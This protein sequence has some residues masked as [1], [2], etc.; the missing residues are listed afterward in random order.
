[1]RLVFITERPLN[2]DEANALTNI[3]KA[4]IP[5]LDP[6]ISR[7]VQ[8]NYIKR[9]H[10]V[11]HPD[12]DVL[13]DIPTIGWVRAAQDY[14]AVPADLTHKARWAKAQGHHVDIAEHPNAEAGVRGIGSDASVRSHL[15][16]AVQHL[17]LA[18]PVPE[19]VSFADHSIAIV[20]QLQEMV[21]QHRT[22]IESNLRRHHRYWSDVLQ[23]LPD[24]MIDWA[25]W[26]LDHPGALKR[27]TI[28]L[29]KEERK[30]VDAAATREAIYAHVARTIER[31]RSGDAIDPFK[32][33]ANEVLET[34]PVVL[35]VA[36]TGSRKST[37]MRDAAV[38][39]VA[40]HPE[41]SVVILMPRHKLG[42]EQIELLQQK[43]SG[44]DAA[45]W[46]GRHAWDPEIRG[47]KMCW[48]EEEAKELEMALLNVEHHLC[49][50]GRGEKA[51]KC[52]FFD[53]C[54][55]QRQKQ[56][57][58][59]IW[60][61]AH[62]CMTHEMPKV[63]GKVGWVIIDES[64]LDA[65]MFGID[66]ND[67][68]TLVLDAL[69]SP[70]PETLNERD[71]VELTDGRKALYRAL[72]KLRVPIEHY[73]GIPVSR[74]SLSA[75]INERRGNAIRIAKYD[76]KHLRGLEWRGKVEPDIRPD[77]TKKE[78]LEELA[79]AAGNG[80]VKKCAT[81]WQ[82]IEEVEQS[83]DKLH[84]RIQVHRGEGR[85]IRMVGLHELAKGWNV[86]TLICDA[87][88]NAK[89]LRAIWPQLEED[90]MQDWQQ[91]PRPK[92]VRVF[93]CVN[94]SISKWAIAI[95][96]NEK[97]LAR[98]I[99]SARRVY[100]AVLMKALEYGGA[101]VGV[102]IYKATETWIRENCCVPEWLK[103]YHHGDVTGT[104]A[105]ANVRALFVIGRPLASPEDVTRQA[106]ALFGTYIRQR[107]YR[108]RRKQGRI[109]IVPDAAGNN[110]ILVD[111]WEHPNPRAERVRRQVTEA[112]LIQAVG[113]ARAGLR[114]A[115]EPLDIHLWTDVPLPELGP[116]E[117]V[118]WE[119][120]AADL[121][122]VMLATGGMWLESIPHA[123]EAYNGLFKADA[124]KWVR[125][126]GG[127]SLLIGSPYR[128]TT[129]T[130]IIRYQR[131]GK[132][133][134]PQHALALMDPTAARAWLE[135]KLG[136]L[137]QCEVGG[138]PV[139]GVAS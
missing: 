130:S 30:E 70:P 138:M 13:G 99:E 51:I 60:F 6:S 114:K 115:D 38:Q 1:V 102:I 72:D 47:K 39:Y 28:R 54:G 120:V 125:K 58:A 19:V 3:A 20:E 48:R 43:H 53:R 106:E 87:T 27:K 75:F 57:E 24:N 56:I 9:P 63:F 46:R 98:K 21:E 88:G 40:E 67:Q 5:K 10:W 108:L 17:L 8:P 90:T 69:R 111:V 86:R 133:Q 18:N 71:A 73:K 26:L 134:R 109:P 35:L 112:A 129:S 80:L 85:I 119:D 100:A 124:L 94:R 2:V 23:Y 131:A 65:F 97:A 11:E 31:A 103:L 93:Q 116:V 110:C 14:L 12:R 126:G 45:V 117:P 92:S 22:E 32:E 81:L 82:L 25:H 127:G 61:A 105:L 66:I 135:E 41:E 128:Q 136:P 7:Q 33:L 107:E 64:P 34:P 101:D 121:D 139:A 132:G 78:V 29:S 42:D 95:E 68:V 16:A 118:L 44:T 76:A 91:L 83:E 84:G 59:S 37:L 137:V 79:K 113:R 96:G 50:Q 122:G 74:P 52:R 49:K 4:R 55:Y 89:L 123:V 104:N 15:M 77:M 62:E 36:P